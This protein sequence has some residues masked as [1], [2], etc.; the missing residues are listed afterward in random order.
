MD[1]WRLG[2]ILYETVFGSTFYR[3]GLHLTDAFVEERFYPLWS[4]V[5]YEF[6]AFVWILLRVRT[7]A[8]EA[9]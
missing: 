9:L 3:K 2:C 1:I 7:Y 8:Q 6:A 4:M 5:S